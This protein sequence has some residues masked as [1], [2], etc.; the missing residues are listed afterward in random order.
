VLAHTLLY[1]RSRC[2]ALVERTLMPPQASLLVTLGIPAL[3]L[4]VLTALALLVW[5]ATRDPR[6]L[7]R[8]LLGAAL[9]L[10]FSSGLALSGFLARVDLAPLPLLP[11]LVPTL[12]LPLWL[13]SSRIGRALVEATPLTALVGFQAFRLPLELVMHEAAREG[14]MPEQ[15]TFTGSNFD[16]VTG[17]SALLLALA[18]ARGPVPHWVLLA[19]NAL[20]SVTLCAIIAIAVASLPQFHAFGSAPDELNT[21]VSYFPFVWLPTILVSAALL[22][23]V[24]MWRRLLF[25]TSPGRES[26]RSEPTAGWGEHNKLRSR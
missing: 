12:G 26:E 14:T 8:F 13:G 10:G 19:W 2:Y 7:G 23:H 4:L 9:W 3:A 24:L 21:W 11:I 16:I 20:G 22:G 1:C 15:M 17:A 6:L 25:R 18:L 5:Q